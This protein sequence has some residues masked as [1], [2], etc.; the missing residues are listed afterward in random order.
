MGNDAAY[1]RG[2]SDGKGRMLGIRQPQPEVAKTQNT[3]RGDRHG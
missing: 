2:Q 1:E 3:E